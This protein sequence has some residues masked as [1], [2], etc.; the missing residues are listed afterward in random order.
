MTTQNETTSKNLWRE[1]HHALSTANNI[2]FSGPEYHLLHNNYKVKAKEADKAAELAEKLAIEN[3]VKEGLHDGWELD[4]FIKHEDFNRD[5]EALS[6]ETEDRLQIEAQDKE[7]EYLAAR[8]RTV[9]DVSE[10]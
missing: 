2:H 10:I 1:A 5:P 7:Q 4:S 9:S 3:D 6:E 8:T